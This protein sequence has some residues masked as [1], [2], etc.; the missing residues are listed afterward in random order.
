MA[1]TILGYPWKGSLALVV[2][3]RRAAFPGEAM[4]GAGPPECMHLSGLCVTA[5]GGTV[6][7]AGKGWSD[8]HAL[9]CDR[10]LD[11][12]PKLESESCQL[13]GLRSFLPRPLPSI[14]LGELDMSFHVWKWM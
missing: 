7:E 14:P 4:A 3:V 8:F 5:A 6:S 13:S 11:G 12:L 10:A 1:P 2:A 9:C